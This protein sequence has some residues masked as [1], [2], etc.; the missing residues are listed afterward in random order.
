[1]RYW[2]ADNSHLTG[3]EKKALGLTGK[4]TENESS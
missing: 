2:L 1:M 4:K 3:E